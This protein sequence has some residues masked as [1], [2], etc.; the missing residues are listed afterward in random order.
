VGDVGGGR[1]WE[2]EEEGGIGGGAEAHNITK[3]QK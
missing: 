3:K 2:R 1:R